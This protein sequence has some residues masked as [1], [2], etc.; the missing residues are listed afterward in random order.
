MNCV[1][2]HNYAPPWNQLFVHLAANYEL[3]SSHH[4][5]KHKSP[6]VLSWGHTHFLVAYFCT[7]I[8][9]EPTI[10]KFSQEKFSRERL[11]FHYRCY[12]KTEKNFF[13]PIRCKVNK[14]QPAR[15]SVVY[16]SPVPSCSWFYL[17]GDI[18]IAL[19][20]L[21]KPCSATIML[22]R[23]QILHTIG[24]I[25]YRNRSLLW[26]RAARTWCHAATFC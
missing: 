17:P 4:V 16:P 8:T 18:E 25:N 9:R 6:L 11:Y 10:I 1:L 12:R 13:L 22:K 24:H 21:K 19:G 3:T 26:E 15:S 20:R 23:W 7:H 2:Q 5:I 14:H